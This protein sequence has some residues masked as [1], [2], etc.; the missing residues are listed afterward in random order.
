M[1]NPPRANAKRRKAAIGADVYV[2]HPEP[3][4]IGK[5]PSAHRAARLEVPD[6]ESLAAV[7]A[8]ALDHLEA[9]YISR[10]SIPFAFSR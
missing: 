8:L 1:A 7:L 4:T 9:N 5:V 2:S 10:A 6:L 3:G